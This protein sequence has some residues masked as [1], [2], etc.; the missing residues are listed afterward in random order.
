MEQLTARHVD[1]F[2]KGLKVGVESGEDLKS[3]SLDDG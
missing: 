3:K 1:R 2:K